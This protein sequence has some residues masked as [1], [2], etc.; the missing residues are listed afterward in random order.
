MTPAA[1]LSTSAIHCADAEESV[2]GCALIYH[3][4]CE[5]AF[6]RLKPEHFY[7]PV[8][9][10]IWARILAKRSKGG[11]PEVISITDAMGEDEAFAEIGGRTYL[12]GLVADASGWTIPAHVDAILDRSVRREVQRLGSK[13]ATR[14]HDTAGA[15]GEALLADLERSAADIARSNSSR[16]LAVPAGLSAPENLEAAWRGEYAGASVGLACVD[17]VTGGIRQDDV[18]FIGGR[19]SMG[20]SAVALSLT[21]GI[22]QDGRGVLFFSLEMPFREVQARLIADIAYDAEAH[23]DA[24]YGGNVGYGDLLRGRGHER[25]RD[26]ARAAA[27]RLA[28]LPIAVTDIGGLT[29]DDI[30]SQGLR[31]IRA[32]ERSGVKP[33]ALVIDHIGLVRPVRK[34]DNKAAD[35][36]DIVNELKGLAK[37]VRAP[38]IALAQI[39]RA[40]ESRQDKRPTMSDM[41]WSGSIEQIADLV[42]LLYRESYYLE[43]GTDDEFMRAHAV[44]NDI[45]LIITKNRSG[46]SLT[47]KA[48]VDIACNALRD[49][50]GERRAVG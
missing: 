23:Y 7:E 15:T 20:K 9:A 32:W 27:R 37:Q 29:I 26:R 21:R 12:V 48:F 40:T 45:D 10:R 49:K 35:T 14:A 6:E 36:A 31:Q 44:R 4:Q 13:V 47:L 1:Q 39:N 22:A 50:P 5:D 28:S 3:D 16:V 34:T 42:C 33:G 18:W 2:I 17:E 41:N 38:V 30:R 11:M 8:R 46:P 43:R 24:S 19:T 25:L